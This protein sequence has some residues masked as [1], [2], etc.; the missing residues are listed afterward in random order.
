MALAAQTGGRS[1]FFHVKTEKR[2]VEKER[3]K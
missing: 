3:I 2:E 1:M